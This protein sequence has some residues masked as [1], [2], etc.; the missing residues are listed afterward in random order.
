MATLIAYAP[1]S[2]AH[3]RGCQSGLKVKL[4]YTNRL[5]KTHRYHTIPDRTEGQVCRE[6]VGQQAVGV[7][8]R[9]DQAA[10]QD[11]PHQQRS[12]YSGYEPASRQFTASGKPC[13][14]PIA[15]LAAIYASYRSISTSRPSLNCNSP[16][17]PSNSITM[18]MARLS[19]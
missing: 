14:E 11:E 2:G 10:N 9:R 6:H 5:R 15:P 1:G 3:A 16:R 17:E 8:R 7:W 19:I 4:Q 12:G 13:C 18:T